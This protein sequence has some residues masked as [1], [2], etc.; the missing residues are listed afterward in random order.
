MEDSSER[1]VSATQRHQSALPGQYLGVAV[2]C[3]PDGARQGVSLPLQ[4][5][6]LSA[7]VVKT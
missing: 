5:D 3:L 7:P 1:V 2:Q 4:S 6:R